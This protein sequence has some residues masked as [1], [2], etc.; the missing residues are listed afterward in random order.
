MSL[1]D[2]LF[3]EIIRDHEREIES[4]GFS[5]SIADRLNRMFTAQLSWALRELADIGTFSPGKLHKL[6][7]KLQN[8]GNI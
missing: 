3:D 7:D 5:G 8:T 1:E 2:K 6:A 4:M